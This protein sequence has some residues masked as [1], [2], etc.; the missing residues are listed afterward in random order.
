MMRWIPV[1]ESLPTADQWFAGI[2]VKYQRDFESDIVSGRIYMFRNC[3]P[4]FPLP[5][6]MTHWYPLPTPLMLGGEAITHSLTVEDVR[7]FKTVSQVAPERC[8]GARP[9]PA[10][11]EGVADMVKTVLGLGVS[12]KV[13]E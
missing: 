12:A 7:D 8:D 2:T 1:T 3:Y 6:D 5:D 9:W 10:G 13:V 11:K 4:T